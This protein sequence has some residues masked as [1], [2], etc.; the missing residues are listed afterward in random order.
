MPCSVLD[1]SF[2]LIKEIPESLASLVSIHT[3]YFVQN[4]ISRI[5][6]LDAIGS[7]LQSLEL[8]GNRLRV[9]RHF[10]SLAQP[11]SYLVLQDN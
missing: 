2:N 3:I 1:L 9:C 6:N 4:K 7:T 10:S 5:Q 8:G 11:I